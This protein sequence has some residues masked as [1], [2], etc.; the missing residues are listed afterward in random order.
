MD[1]R[2]WL[3]V[4]ASLAAAGWG[5]ALVAQES[6]ARTVRIH[7]KKFDFVPSEITL[8]RGEP[9]L[10]ELIADDV[11]MGFRCKALDLRADVVPGKPAQLRF[12]PQAAGEFPFYCDVFCGEG[13]EDMDGHII[14]TG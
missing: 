6:A 2:N 11:A 10:L 1:R 7:T 14:V 12:T 8:T 4:A 5:C 9:V 13:H 3:V